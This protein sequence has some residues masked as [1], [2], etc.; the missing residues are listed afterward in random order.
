MR[1]H[2]GSGLAVP[3]REYQAFRSYELLRLDLDQPF[4]AEYAAGI[5]ESRRSLA[6]LH[7]SNSGEAVRAALGHRP[8]D[9]RKVA[10]DRVSHIPLAGDFLFGFAALFAI[11]NPY[12]LAFIFHDR[13]IGLTDRE[14]ARIAVRIAL[15][16]FAVILMS[17]F[18]G[19]HV[20]RF[21]GITMPALGIGGG[22]VVAA[23][24]WSMLHAPPVAHDMH[25][26]PTAGYSAIRRMAFFPMTIP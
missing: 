13:T 8:A 21:F 25:Q 23:S 26:T 12:G 10:Y 5:A 1:S 11:I 22:L 19:G 20:L 18:V 14:R 16:A 6:C 24:G 4:K 2:W 9:K 17:L 15:Y 3:T 7:K